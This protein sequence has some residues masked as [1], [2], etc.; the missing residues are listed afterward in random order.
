[1]HSIHFWILTI[2][3]ISNNCIDDAGKKK[4]I[5]HPFGWTIKWN[6]KYAFNRNEKTFSSSFLI[7]MDRDAEIANA[8]EL[9]DKRLHLRKLSVCVCVCIWKSVGNEENKN[10]QCVLSKEWKDSLDSIIIIV[11]DIPFFVRSIDPVCEREG[12]RK[13]CFSNAEGCHMI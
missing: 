1:M 6:K 8:I 7:A 10:E 12:K 4:Q 9:Q 3:C 5:K 13:K 11:V 2:E